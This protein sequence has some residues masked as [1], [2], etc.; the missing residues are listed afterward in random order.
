MQGL[1]RRTLHVTPELLR[2][3]ESL[4]LIFCLYSNSFPYSFLMLCTQESNPSS[5]F[6][7]RGNYNL[8]ENKNDLVVIWL[9]SH[10]K[11]LS[12][13]WQLSVV[14]NAWSVLPPSTNQTTLDAVSLTI[15]L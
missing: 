1:E 14:M 8:S 6:D 11:K 9:F 2:A 10:V 3:Y 13:F 5:G 4:C 15:I 12:V 7:T